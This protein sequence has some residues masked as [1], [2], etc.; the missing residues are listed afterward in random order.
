[1]PVDKRNR[2][3][4]GDE[5]EIETGADEGRGGVRGKQGNGRKEVP[6]VVGA[7]VSPWLARGSG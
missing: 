5:R 1:V 3:E 6:V 4:E 2:E 7:G